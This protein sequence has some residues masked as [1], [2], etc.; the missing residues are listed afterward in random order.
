MDINKHLLETLVVHCLPQSELPSVS[1]STHQKKPSSSD[2][3]VVQLR[4]MLRIGSA[5]AILKLRKRLLLLLMLLSDSVHT[6]GLVIF[7]ELH[8]FMVMLMLHSRVLMYLRVYSP[9]FTLTMLVVNGSDIVHHLAML[10]PSTVRLA[11]LHSSMV[12][13]IL[14]RSVFMDIMVMTEILE[15]QVHCS[16]SIV[17]LR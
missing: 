12:M 11:D 17:Q 9:G 16:H 13:V 8:S 7:L 6:G 1:D 15:L 5:L 3:L 14:V 10:T 4:N 2:S